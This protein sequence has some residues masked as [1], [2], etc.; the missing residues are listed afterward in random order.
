MG[1]KIINM[2]EEESESEAEPE[3]E[4]AAALDPMKLYVYL[5]EKR[6]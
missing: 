3:E 4:A 5:K 2:Q 1:M 6:N